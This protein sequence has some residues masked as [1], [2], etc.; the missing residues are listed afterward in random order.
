MRSPCRVR[1]QAKWILDTAECMRSEVLLYYVPV[2]EIIYAWVAYFNTAFLL[3]CS[4][5]PSFELAR[6]YVRARLTK[7]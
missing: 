4:L 7:L 6:V 2:S 3:F 1:R 5:G